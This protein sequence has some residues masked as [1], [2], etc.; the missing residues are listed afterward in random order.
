MNTTT[1]RRMG[2]AG[3]AVW[4]TILDAA[5][6][7]LRQEGYA[8]LTSRNIAQRAGTKQQLV[9]YYFRTMDDLIVAMIRRS[10]ERELA[11]LETA[12][13]GDHALHDLWAICI[14][15]VSARLITELM[16]LANHNDGLRVEVIAF[17][18]TSRRIQAQALERALAKSGR[19]ASDL[20]PLA[21]AF[22][23]TS[24]ALALTREAELGV[25]LGHA[26][27]QRLIEQ[28]LGGLEPGP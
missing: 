13:E 11:R 5:E 27:V 10:S 25:T 19:P 28:A 15:T 8:E 23:A 21:A 6:S 2:P 1:T 16:A 14:N 26:D 7:I 3:S 17:I 20:T 18:E 24:A 9:Y 12:L 4:H 22:I